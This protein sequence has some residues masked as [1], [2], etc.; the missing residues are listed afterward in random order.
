[1]H[2]CRGCRHAAHL[3]GLFEVMADLEKR[4]RSVDL[5]VLLLPH[6]TI[7]AAAVQM[8]EWHMHAFR[9]FEFSTPTKILQV[10]TPEAACQIAFCCTHFQSSSCSHQQSVVS[11][12]NRLRPRA[13]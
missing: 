3:V 8:E 2:C 13:K 7:E 11:S 4:Q 1:M 5:L 9:L 6:A 10:L 12:R